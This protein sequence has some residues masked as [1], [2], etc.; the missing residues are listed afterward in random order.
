MK[1]HDIKDIKAEIQGCK[2]F[3]CGGY[4]H[5]WAQ[6]PSQGSL[7]FRS[8]PDLK[9]GLHTGSPTPLQGFPCKHSSSRAMPEAGK[10]GGLPVYWYTGL[11][12]WAPMEVTLKQDQ[13]QVK[14]Q[15]SPN[16]EKKFGLST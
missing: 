1:Y 15:K 12:Y 16:A 2:G 11:V 9:S 8:L 6:D 14:Q 10:S 13:G 4:F 3:H 5:F 7:S